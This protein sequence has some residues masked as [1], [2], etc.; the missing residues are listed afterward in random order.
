MWTATQVEGIIS[1]PS[2]MWG[3][4]IKLRSPGWAADVFS[5][6]AISP[7]TTTFIDLY[8]ASNISFKRK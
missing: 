8:Y 1:P 3:L 5:C 2:I 4:G 6:W 7:T